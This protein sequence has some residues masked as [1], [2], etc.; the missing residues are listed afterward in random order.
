[1]LIYLINGPIRW[2]VVHYNSLFFFCF[3]YKS[4]VFFLSLTFSFHLVVFIFVRSTITSSC[5]LLVG[6]PLILL[7]AG[8]QL[9]IFL[10][11][12]F[13]YFLSTCQ[14]HRSFWEV[15]KLTIYYPPIIFLFHVSKQFLSSQSKHP[16]Y[17]FFL[18]CIFR[19]DQLFQY[20]RDCCT[21][22]NNCILQVL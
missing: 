2:L 4:A 18:S 19:L 16:S 1:M 5:H 17:L 9:S 22:I 7:A 14:N 10:L 3:I 13:G 21:F 15:I 6:L 8:L 11:T 20:T 12:S